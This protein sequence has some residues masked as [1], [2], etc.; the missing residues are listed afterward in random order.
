MKSHLA[1]QLALTGLLLVPASTASASKTANEQV[2]PQIVRLSLVDGDV[3]ISR[4][5][6]Q[7]QNKKADW[8][9]AIS[10]LPLETGFSIATGDGR[11]VVE[12]QD[13]STLYLAPQSIL[14]LNDLTAKGDVP[15]SEVALLSGTVTLHVHPVIPDDQFVLRTPTDTM[16]VKY[17]D[18]NDFRVTA[19]MD[20]LAL[21]PLREAVVARG[22]KNDKTIPGVTMYYRAG[23]RVNVEDKG[24]AA[25]MASWDKWVS[26]K[27]AQRIAAYNEVSNEGGLKV[28]A[29][30]LDSLAGK[31]KFVDC[32]EYGKCWEPPQPPATP[33]QPAGQAQVNTASNAMVAPALDPASGAAGTSP[34][35]PV[36]I[37]KVSTTFTPSNAGGIGLGY[38][39]YYFPCGPG[40]FYYNTMS[41]GYGGMMP[42]GGYGYGG[43]GGYGAYPGYAAYGGMYDPALWSWAV[44]HTGSWLYMDNRYLWVPGSQI[45]YQPPVQWIKSG[46]R[47]GYVPIH[48]RDINGHTPVN[49]RNGLIA[50][51][52]RNSMAAGPIKIDNTRSVKLLNSPPRAFREGYSISLA[53]A[54]SPRLEGRVLGAGGPKTLLGSNV[55]SVAISFDHSSQSFMVARPVGGNSVKTVNEPVGSFLAR[56]GVGGFGGPIGLRTGV[57]AAGGQS[58]FNG[59][60]NGEFRGGAVFN[61]GAP[62]GGGEYSGF[63]GAPRMGANPTYSGGYSGGVSAGG[64]G[65]FSGGGGGGGSVG[66]GGFGGGMGGGHAA[67]GGAP[68]AP[69]NSAH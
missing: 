65:G 35:Q 1:F 49:L 50:V 26:E 31:G 56:S 22:D 33:Q 52:G 53:R 57:G 23:K 44:C 28:L 41:Y 3:R 63:G 38:S 42:M 36:I 43:Y 69:A 10:G 34:T 4:D 18:R 7:G 51:N 48:P 21:T 24:D 32:G 16:A 47:Q 17:P 66:G 54:N 60:R 13:A 45:H 55:R 14:V 68:S 37:R 39:P 46:R 64:G 61:G 62:R 30:G 20:A 40:S 15:H 29:P 5:H 25:A 12:F 58:A 59:G 2:E 6:Q 27:F 11:A 19:Y 9:T 8:E 67:G